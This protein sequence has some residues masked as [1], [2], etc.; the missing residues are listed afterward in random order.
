M[1][2]WIKIYRKIFDNP[3]Y[4]SEKFTRCQAW[5]DLLLLANYSEGFFY[6]R[7]IKVDI[8]R[9]QIGYDLDSLGLRWRW[10][11]GK[12]ERFINDLEIEKQIV[13][14][15]TNVTTLITVT[16]YELY[17]SD[18]KA[19]DNADG[20]Q[21]GT[22]TEPNKKNKKTKKPKNI[23]I[24]DDV[25]SSYSKC[26]DIYNS[27][28][29]NQT[30]VKPIINGKQGIAAKN[31]I[32]YFYDNS[33]DKPPTNESIYNGFNFIFNNYQYWSEFQKGNLDLCFIHSKIVDIINSILENKK[34]SDKNKN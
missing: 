27:F 18:S 14:Q 21:T 31:L 28:V 1:S 20:Q 7:G 22:Q 15:K 4:F 17:Q 16:N 11:R 10:S 6:K 5:I 9:G 19:D 13:R 33:K 24:Y 29:V 26:I 34:K 23:E 25:K 2:G 8:K 30:T 12:V 32:N 3:F